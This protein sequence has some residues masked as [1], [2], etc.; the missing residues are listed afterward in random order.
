[1][2]LDSGGTEDPDPISGSGNSPHKWVKNVS[3]MFEEFIFSLE[4]GGFSWSFVEVLEE[5]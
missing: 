4:D 3:C 1:M 2:D 5:M